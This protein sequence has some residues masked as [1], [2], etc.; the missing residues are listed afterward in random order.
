MYQPS[1]AA[2][3]ARGESSIQLDVSA[4]T[5]NFQPFDPDVPLLKEEATPSTTMLG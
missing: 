5:E 1:A 4:A 2:A 3:A